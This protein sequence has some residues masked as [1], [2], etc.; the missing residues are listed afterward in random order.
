MPTDDELKESVKVFYEI[1]SIKEPTV[2][3]FDNPLECQICASILREGSFWGDVGDALKADYPETYVKVLK[4]LNENVEQIKSFGTVPINEQGDT[5]TPGSFDFESQ[6]S[7][8][9]DDE[10]ESVMD[11]IDDDLVPTFSVNDDEFPYGKSHK[12]NTLVE[13]NQKLSETDEIVGPDTF[14][15]P[16]T[17]HKPT[18]ALVNIDEAISKHISPVFTLSAST[19]REKTWKQD[20]IVPN[21]EDEFLDQCSA[22][23]VNDIKNKYKAIVLDSIKTSQKF[24][25]CHEIYSGVNSDI[26][27]LYGPLTTMP[28]SVMNYGVFSIGCYIDFL[29]KAGIVDSTSSLETERLLK[30]GNISDEY[31][32]TNVELFDLH[33]VRDAI[34]NVPFYIVPMEEYVAI[35]RR[36]TKIHTDNLGKLHR[37]DGPVIEFK[38]FG[39][40]FVLNGY[41]LG[42]EIF[43]K[44]INK[45]LEFEEAVGISSRWE[46]GRGQGLADKIIDYYAEDVKRDEDE[47]LHN[48]HGPALIW[49]GVN[50]FFVK[51]VKMEVDIYN[52][53]FDNTLTANE[54]FAIENAEVKTIALIEIGLDNILKAG[55]DNVKVIDEEE[56]KSKITGEL[57][58][59]ELYQINMGTTGQWNSWRRNMKVVKVQDHTSGKPALLIVPPRYDNVQDAIAWTF[60]MAGHD[61][62]PDME[63]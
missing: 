8:D 61:Y 32:E 22:T 40:M 10:F 1:S 20:I 7:H 19:A 48:K 36:P 13:L 28:T 16:F 52:K 12:D 45:K 3:L 9:L 63:S 60:G 17:P 38:G 44:L 55:S 11:A 33:H 41:D 56:V 54:L 37:L 14:D 31:K 24:K 59:Y 57:L 18:S 46:W 30:H 53:I 21:S 4:I 49:N 5:L 26:F 25:F 58:K 39:S 51:G 62:K 6:S 42:R 15:S 2:L 47:R 43:S 35:S 50:Q 27:S 29:I 23:A 34:K